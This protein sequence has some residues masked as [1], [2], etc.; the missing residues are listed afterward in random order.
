MQSG[1][2]GD[3]EGGL[4]VVVRPIPWPEVD[5]HAPPPA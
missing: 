4:V 5:H 1:A 3:L 2:E